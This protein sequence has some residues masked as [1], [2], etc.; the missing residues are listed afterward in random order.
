[1][2]AAS[3]AQLAWL[4]A[5]LGAWALFG[6]TGRDAWT[7]AEAISL[8][9]L[10]DLRAGEPVP[11]PAFTLL[12][13]LTARLA[14]PWLDLQDGARLASGLWTLAALLF[15]ALAARELF[16]PAF[17]A[18]AALA[19]M[20]GFGLMLRAHAL[21]PE[22]VLLTAHAG[23]LYALALA[24]RR[25]LAGGLGLGLALALLA[26]ARGPVD[27]LA[28]LA[29]VA[30]AAALP[31]ARL[32]ARSWL[33]LAATLTPPLAAWFLLRDGQA[34]LWLDLPAPN[35]D[36]FALFKLLLWFAWPLWPLA[37]WTLWHQHRRLGRETPLH[38]LL[39]SLVVLFMLALWPTHSREGAALPLLAPL[40]LLAAHGVASLQRG[41]AQAFYWFGVVTF[42][43]FA[44]AFWVYFAAL[45]WGW[46]PALSAHLY[47][48]TPAYPS[49]TLSTADLGVAVAASLAWLVAIPLFPRASV[50]P[51]L[52]WATGMALTWFLLISLLR[53]WAEAGWGYRPLLAGIEAALPASACVDAEV[54]PAMHALLRLRLGDRLGAGADCAHLLRLEP[55]RPRA[56]AMTEAL[57]AE[58][59]ATDTVLW[60][61]FRP[62]N[63]TRVYTLYRR[64]AG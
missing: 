60:S 48:L 30:L 44:V 9:W 17:V 26:L 23:L 21:L 63:K 31:G 5:L 28:G 41:A 24:R 47:R 34:T 18:P 42:L 54:D 3:R 7:P 56:T 12:A 4:F 49:G 14:A 6:L 27:L 33:A 16:G 10:L 37:L 53:P 1:M 32:P 25:P 20:G 13:D 64:D 45:E 52:V 50:R 40:A 43:F 59:T 15:T 19:L 58:S 35:H 38:P 57:P 51:I 8:G 39:I 36:P 11:A 55:T 29:I 2:Q 61:G 62:R 22:I 46:P